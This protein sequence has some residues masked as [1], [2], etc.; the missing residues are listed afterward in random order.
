[1][2][3][4]LKDLIADGEALGFK[5]EALR[6]FVKTQQDIQREERQSDSD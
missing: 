6:D 4:T 2:P 5:D 3:S 1:M